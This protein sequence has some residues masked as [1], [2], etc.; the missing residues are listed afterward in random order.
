M[1]VVEVEVLEL[2]VAEDHKDVRSHL[3]E[4]GVHHVEPC[5][6]TR[7]LGDSLFFSLNRHIRAVRRT[8]L[9]NALPLFWSQIRKR[10]VD[11][12]STPTSCAICASPICN[13]RTALPI[14]SSNYRHS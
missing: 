3:F 14:G 1:V 9:T 13:G 10:T 2:I 4:L 6:N 7:G 8:T 12:F 11:M 5:A